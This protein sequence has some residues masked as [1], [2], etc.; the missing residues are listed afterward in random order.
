M[1]LKP[2]EPGIQTSAHAQFHEPNLFLTQRV[3][4]LGVPLLDLSF[5]PSFEFFSKTN[6]GLVLLCFV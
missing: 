4:L 3:V 1:C 2:F 5:E 6:G